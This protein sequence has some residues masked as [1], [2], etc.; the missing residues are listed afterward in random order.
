MQVNNKEITSMHQLIK[1][2]I[3]IRETEIVDLLLPGMQE[4]V[5][6]VAR[7][8]RTTD[9][10]R[11]MRFRIVAAVGNKNGYIGIGHAKGKEAGPTIRKAIEKAK[12]DVMEVKRGC[13]SWECGC[14]EPHTVPFK[15]MGK[16][17]SVS[18]SIAPAPKGTGLV[19]GDAAK[20]IL[21][22][23]GVNDAWVQTMG[24]T[25]T[26]MNFVYAVLDALE[27]TNY[28]KITNTEV[29]NLNIIS[30]AASVEEAVSDHSDQ[31]PEKTPVNQ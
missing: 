8:Q 22:L 28:M 25:R 27:H 30:G 29:K 9:S 6:D 24:H 18:V 4:E 16:T 12:M 21:S 10:G 31:S 19:S 17:G 11:R 5:I 7:V 15:V 1:M 20:K 26:S 3:P 2:G 13:G 14:G 23:A